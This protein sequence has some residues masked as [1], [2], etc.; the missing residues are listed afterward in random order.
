M[1]T[2]APLLQDDVD[3]E[4]FSKTRIILAFSNKLLQ[5]QYQAYCRHRFDVQ[6]LTAQTILVCFFSFCTLLRNCLVL[7]YILEKNLTLFLIAFC[8][9]IGSAVCSCTYIL[10][11]FNCSNSIVKRFIGDEKRFADFKIYT[12][13]IGVQLFLASIGFQLIGSSALGQCGNGAPKLLCNT[14]VSTPPV[15]ISLNLIA[16]IIFVVSTVKS[17][18]SFGSQIFF[19]SLNLGFFVAAYQVIPDANDDSGWILSFIFLLSVIFFIC[20]DTY[21]KEMSAFEYYVAVTKGNELRVRQTKEQAE[22][23]KHQLKMILANVAHDLKTPLQAFNAGMHSLSVL[24]TA[25]AIPILQDMWASYAFMMMQINRALDVSKSDNNVVLIPNPESFMLRDIVSWAVNIMSSIQSKIRVVVDY[26]DNMQVLG[27]RILTDKVWLQE[28][29]LCL[30]SNACKYSPEDTT[31]T[32]VVKRIDPPSVSLPLAPDAGGSA[33]AMATSRLLIEV[34]DEGVGVSEE[35]RGTLFRPFVQAQRRAGGTGLGLYSLALRVKAL[36]GEFGVHPVQNGDGSIFFFTI[37]L[38]IDTNSV[39]GDEALNVSPETVLSDQRVKHPVSN[40]TIDSNTIVA[41]DQT[42]TRRANADGLKFIVL[43]VDDSPTTLKVL[44]RAI[45]QA[46]AVVDTAT[47][48]FAALKLM[49]TTIYTAVIMDIQM[50]IM[51]CKSDDT[52]LNVKCKL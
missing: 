41:S 36:G 12:F 9:A 19:I 46:G 38:K 22:S 52:T 47:N 25:A 6:G 49:K 28:N 31:V 1:A 43:V 26:S 2:I 24:L 10:A 39:D 20:R 8:L 17:V 37:P 48:G 4:F 21:S 51:V 18:F 33:S 45:K 14:S 7:D 42:V 27:N 50:P 5:A 30:L 3:V 40:K 16:G 44:S 11:Q 29:V 35:M 34:R 23:E 32:V 13:F 15:I